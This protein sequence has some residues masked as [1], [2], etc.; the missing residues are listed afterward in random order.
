MQSDPDTRPGFLNA[1]T[2]FGWVDHTRQVK[3]QNQSFPL[4]PV[5]FIGSATQCWT[6]EHTSAST[7]C[8]ASRKGKAEV[9]LRT[10]QHVLSLSRPLCVSLCVTGSH[11]VRHATRVQRAQ[12]NPPT[13]VGGN[14]MGGLTLTSR[15]EVA[16]FDPIEHPPAKRLAC[17][18]G[19]TQC[20]SVSI[21][22]A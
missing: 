19:I 16:A 5:L 22:D 1:A 14:T 3:V 11:R 10:F 17:R 15:A 6:E 8:L 7:A 13:T 21:G 20:Y 9:C 18:C 2:Q 12:A 4:L